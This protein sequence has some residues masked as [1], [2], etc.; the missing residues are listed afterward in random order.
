MVKK[1]IGQNIMSKKI[2]VFEL[3]EGLD[4]VIIEA[5][6][7]AIGGKVRQYIIENKCIEAIKATH[8]AND[9]RL[10]PWWHVRCLIDFERL[11]LPIER[12][13]FEFYSDR[14]EAR[15]IIQISSK[16]LCVMPY[17]NGASYV[18]NYHLHDT[19]E[20]LIKEAILYVA[21][22]VYKLLLREV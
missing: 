11:L 2:N 14:E 10:G 16:E 8:F 5:I 17:S 21:T 12:N 6:A 20:D 7:K 9:E 13:P 19:K 3:S 1:F 18:Y 22:H 4:D 15:T